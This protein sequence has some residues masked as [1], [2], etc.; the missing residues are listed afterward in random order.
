[1]SSA[2]SYASGRR[3]NCQGASPLS[4]PPPPKSENPGKSS[5]IADSTAAGGDGVAHPIYTMKASYA[6]FNEWLEVAVDQWKLVPVVYE[7]TAIEDVSS[8][9]AEPSFPGAIRIRPRR[10]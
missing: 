5:K 10:F 9:K 1:M 2:E 3:I 6:I 4:T 7:L 8:A